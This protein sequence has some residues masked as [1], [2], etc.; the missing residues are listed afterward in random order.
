MERNGLETTDLH[1][2]KSSDQGKIGYKSGTQRIASDIVNLHTSGVSRPLV[3][4][5][6]K[7]RFLRIKDDIHTLQKS[8]WITTLYRIPYSKILDGV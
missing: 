3:D 5:R 7:I 1:S 4:V 2:H 8:S 6:G